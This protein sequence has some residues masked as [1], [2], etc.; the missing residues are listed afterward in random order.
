[1]ASNAP[2]RN[3]SGRRHGRHASSDER[4]KIAVTRRSTTGPL[5]AVP[6][7][8]LA[9]SS[10]VSP[11]STLSPSAN[12]LS[13]AALTSPMPRGPRP[14]SRSPSP[15]PPKDFSHLLSPS[16]FHPLPTQHIPSAFLHS[17]HQPPPSTPLPELLKQGHHRLAAISA[18]T[19]LVSSTSA[20][21]YVRIFQLLYIRLACL[22]LISQHGIAAQEAK[23]LGDLNSAFYRHPITRRHLVP[24]GLRVLCVRLLSAGYGDGRKGIMG[25]Y[26][27]ARE[28]REG[29][30]STANP[31]QSDVELWTSCLQELGIRVASALIELNDLEAAAI[32][33]KTLNYPNLS[34]SAA[35]RLNMMEALVW[36]R[37]GSTTDAQRCID[38]STPSSSSDNSPAILAALTAT[39]SGDFDAALAVWRDLHAAH[40]ADALVGQNLAVC[41]IYTGHLAKSREVLEGLVDGGHAFRSLTFNLATLYELSSERAREMKLRLA[42]RV[43]EGVPSEEGWEGGLGD[44]KL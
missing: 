4:R 16:N 25:F 43:A 19:S 26:E 20:N 11:S 23:V 3:P 24:W 6:D 30:T 1:M 21:D 5:D 39:A 8:P 40:P 38:A 28:A 13:P 22:C 31:E 7:D 37:I 18:A 34:P 14:T 32:H 17:S 15:L 36:L 2:V 9:A 35:R 29:E 42:G 12:P 44:F 41:L 10:P 27:L 33:L